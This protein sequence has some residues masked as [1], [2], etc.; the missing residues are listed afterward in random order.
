MF[1]KKRTDNGLTMMVSPMRHMSSVSLGIWIGVG[2]RYEPAE[3]SGISHL[4][5]HMLFKGTNTRDAKALKESVEGVGGSFNGFTSDEVTCYMVKVPSRY[6]GLGMEILSDMVL[7]PKFDGG[8]LAKEKFVVC[9]EIKMYRDQPS[10]HVLDLLNGIMWPDNPL[11]RPLTGTIATVKSIDLDKLWAFK[12]GNYHP[13]N[14]AIVATGDV[15]M[16][17]IRKYMPSGFSAMKKK[18]RKKVKRPVVRSTG[19]VVR[20]S[21]DDAQQVHIAMGF[22]ATAKDMRERFA[23]KILNVILGGNMSSRLFEELRE[24]N[25]LCYDISSS[26]KRHSDVGELQIHAGVDTR[27]ASRALDAITGEI[28][29]MKDLGITPD[30]LERAKRYTKGQFEL[31]MEAT[32]SRMLWLGDRLMVHGEVPQVKEVL[33]NIDHVTEEDVLRAS[34]HVFDRRAV[35]LAVVGNVQEKERR[36]MKRGVNG[37]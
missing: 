25:G 35:R 36:V 22:Y 26:Y 8:D 10:E 2:G 21:A 27:K 13:A 29:K 3:V 30:E 4:I 37:L 19:P 24:K 16:G 5:E 9:E 1:E 31:A 18:D 34:R 32:S 15:D 6:T 28:K 11:G 23:I 12:K 14:I 17:V 33:A 20:F 7:D